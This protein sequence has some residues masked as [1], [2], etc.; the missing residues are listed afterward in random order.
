LEWAREAGNDGRGDVGADAFGRRNCCCTLIR[1]DTA[2]PWG[3]KDEVMN[4]R[5]DLMGVGDRGGEDDRSK[6]IDGI[7]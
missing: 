1:R 7:G 3:V 2:S 6:E 5:R 4:V